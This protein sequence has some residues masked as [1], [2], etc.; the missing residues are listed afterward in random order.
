MSCWT[1]KTAETNKRSLQQS[2]YDQS[3]QLV[4]HQNTS[5]H[6]RF[7]NSL[8]WPLS[9]TFSAQT[10]TGLQPCCKDQSQLGQLLPIIIYLEVYRKYA[11]AKNSI[12]IF[13]TKPSIYLTSSLFQQ[14]TLYKNK[15][16]LYTCWLPVYKAHIAW[17]SHTAET[18]GNEQNNQTSECMGT[19]RKLHCYSCS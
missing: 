7:Y 10:G 4:K 2:D 16:L 15:L 5:A 19:I 12:A 6:L 13:F 1:M 9:N 14:Y 8:H 18:A 17:G 3:C 11:Y